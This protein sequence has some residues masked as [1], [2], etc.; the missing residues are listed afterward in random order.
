MYN[1]ADAATFD[2]NSNI[3][4]ANS[5]STIGYCGVTTVGGV[6]TPSPGLVASTN[7]AL[8]G[9]TF[10]L[11]GIGVGGVNGIP[12]GLV[13]D[14]WNNWGPRLGWAYDLTGQA[15]TVLRGGFGMMYERI[16]G[17][18][19]YNGAVNPPGDPNPTLNGVSLDNPRQHSRREIPSPLPPASASSRGHRH[20][21]A[22]SNSGQLPVQR[23]CP[24]S[25]WKPRRIERFL[26]GQPG[27][28]RKLL[29]GDQPAAP[30]SPNLPAEAHTSAV[31]YDG[32]TFTDSHLSSA[33]A[34]CGCPT[35]APTPP[36]TR[37]RPL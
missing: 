2:S 37:S 26:R 15:K 5:P 22:L 8:G 14:S 13:N 7:P 34:T 21:R 9:Y 6:N 12:K 30:P 31:N 17:N 36:I 3:C 35:T 28:A 19:M 1:Q 24:A 16:Q 32:E 18:D 10:Y 23:G 20:R 33:M 11:N 29:P 4:S 25:G 27:P